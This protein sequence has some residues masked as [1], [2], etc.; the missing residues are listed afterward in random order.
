MICLTWFFLL[1]HEKLKIRNWKGSH[2]QS[3]I[4]SVF[5]VSCYIL[6]FKSIFLIFL[7]LI[8]GSVFVNMK[9]F[10]FQPRQVINNNVGI[11]T[12]IRG[13]EE[14]N[15]EEREEDEQEEQE[16]LGEVDEEEERRI[17]RRIIT[18][19]ILM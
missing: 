10:V 5:L 3:S 14:L 7:L 1:L 19:R 17:I 8:T 9:V 6:S 16:E 13:E 18:R 15:E 2:H 11:T 12:L 4:L